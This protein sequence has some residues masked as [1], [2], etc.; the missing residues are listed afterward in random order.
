M[1]NYAGQIEISKHLTVVPVRVVEGPSAKIVHTYIIDNHVY[2]KTAYSNDML[3]ICGLWKEDGIWIA[4]DN[5]AGDCWTEEF[6]SKSAAL[7]WIF[8]GD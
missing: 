2:A 1:E 7:K 3:T 4:F 6:K 5:R 8:C